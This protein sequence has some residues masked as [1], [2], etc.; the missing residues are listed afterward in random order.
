MFA[1]DVED[2]R[3]ENMSSTELYELLLSREDDLRL[4]AE[5]GQ[6]MVMKYEN[7]VKE[8]HNRHHMLQSQVID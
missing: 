8:S 2:H 3:R 5:I 6:T 1:V 4:A 7:H